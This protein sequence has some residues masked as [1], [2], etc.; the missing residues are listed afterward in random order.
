[1]FLSVSVSAQLQNTTDS[2][3]I[4][5]QAEKEYHFSY[6]S[7]THLNNNA[8]KKSGFV[9]LAYQQIQGHFRAAQ[10]PEKQQ[11]MNV[12]TEG[13]NTLG[14]FKVAGY[15]SFARIYQDSLAWTTKGTEMD[16]QPFY[17]G[18][19]KAGQ[20]ERTN[21]RMGGILSYNLI[22]EKVFI[23]LGTDYNYQ[24]STRSVDPRP[25][26]NNFSLILK[27]E[28][29]FKFK[30][31]SLGLQANW[32][33]GKEDLTLNYKN[34]D[35][36]ENLGYLDRINYLI[37]GYGLIE[38][39]QGTER[40]MRNEQHSGLELN[41][42]GN[43]GR[44]SYLAK[45]G[46]NK[47]IDKNSFRTSNSVTN[48]LI[49]KF[50]LNTFNIDLLLKRVTKKTLQQLSV[51]AVTENGSDKNKTYNATNYHYQQQRL[52]LEYLIKINQDHKSS[53]E[54]GA[55]IG[56]QQLEKKDIISAHYTSTS[57]IEPGISGNLYL[58]LSQKDVLAFYSNI[59]YRLPLSQ[60][61]A[62][63]PFQEYP[64]TRGV[65]YGNYIY[66]NAEALKIN[67][68]I[69]YNTFSILKE[70]KTGISIEGS[71]LSAINLKN[72]YPTA[73]FVPSGKRLTMNLSLN[74]Y[75]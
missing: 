20:F 52:N 60:S 73:S 15:F 34:K 41:Y 66:G 74:L 61:L 51:Q 50:E 67:G 36:K 17:F 35:Y 8:L 59:A 21:Y 39:M 40:T 1:M 16:A 71:Y 22:D 37:H 70:F 7:M 64:F 55:N 29:T 44:Y 5:R 48:N 25:E 13:I 30:N 26:V 68:K 2:L 75:F 33:Y 42:A 57:N 65:I 47:W 46:Y 3:Y 63:S 10:E 32:G 27:P 31:Q 19:E 49:G 69:N 56:Y 4:F 72:N 43:F 23:G 53:P 18:S 38:I 11:K 14:K 62:V 45:T 9:S 54:F 28:I 24:N 58:K 6:K 12:Y